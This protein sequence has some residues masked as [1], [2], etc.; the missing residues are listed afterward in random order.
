ML[1]KLRDIDSI[2][3]LI[4]VIQNPSCK[5]NYEFTPDEFIA[6]RSELEFQYFFHAL[7]ALF[8]IGE[9]YEENRAKIVAAI[10]NVPHQP[11]FYLII[12]FKGIDALEY[13]II[14]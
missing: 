6:N 13:P 14:R 10:K 5:I 3:K 11:D 8:K 12:T 7:M 1:G 2:D 4:K 9:K